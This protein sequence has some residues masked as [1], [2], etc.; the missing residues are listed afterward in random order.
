LQILVDDEK[1]SVIVTY[2]KK[3]SNRWQ[4]TKNKNIM[5]LRIIYVKFNLSAIITIYISFL[6]LFVFK[7]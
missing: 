3:S 2:K 5:T 1:E 7:Q 4:A 6:N